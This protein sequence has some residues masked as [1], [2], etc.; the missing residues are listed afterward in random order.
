MS[1]F[2]FVVMAA[3]IAMTACGGD[4]G[5]DPALYPVDYRTT[6]T[7]VRNCRPSL[8][9]DFMRIRVLASP[10]ALQAYQNRTPFPVG[11]IVLKEQFDMPD[12]NCAGPV[13][14]VT[15]MQKLATGADPEALDW[16]WQKTDQENKVLETENIKRCTGCHT[17]C[18]KPPDGFDG[19]CT[20]P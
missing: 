1:R 8:D 10:E 16:T 17:S 19:T 6:Y 2:L 12:M 5:G 18:G 9:H 13:L 3:S 14:N 7:E 20:V 4:D 11:A 15:V